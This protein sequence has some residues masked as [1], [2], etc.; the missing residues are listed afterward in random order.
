MTMEGVCVLLHVG[1]FTAFACGVLGNAVSGVPDN[2]AWRY[3]V[4][5]H[6]IKRSERLASFVQGRNLGEVGTT[7]YLG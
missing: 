4:F 3:R 7:V 2:G 5:E 6:E 1:W